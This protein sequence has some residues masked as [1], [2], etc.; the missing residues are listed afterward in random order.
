MRKDQR[1]TDTPCRQDQAGALH[2]RGADQSTSEGLKFQSPQHK[3]HPGRIEES[4]LTQGVLRLAIPAVLEQ[5]LVMIV[6]VISTM[7]VGKLGKEALSA[8]GIVNQTIAFILVLSVALSTGSTV[9]VA[10]LIGEGNR[11]D[12]RDAMRQTVVLGAIGFTIVALVCHAF[13]S[14][15]LHLFFGSAEPAVLRHAEAYF[16][17]SMTGLP[18]LLVNTI[19]SG[20]MR[21][22]GNMKAPMFIAGMVNVLNLTLGIL[23]IFG[24][25]MPAIGLELP[26]YGV[27][28]A[29]WAVSIARM[30][31]GIVSLLWIRNGEGP[32][33]TPLLK[34]FRLNLPLLVRTGRVGLPAMLEQ[35]VMQGGFLMIQIVLAGQGTTTMAVMQIGNSVNSIAFIPTWGFGLA[36]TTLIG[37]SMGEGRPEFAKK[38]GYEANRLCLYVSLTLSLALF[39]FAPQLTAMYTDDPEVLAV[40]I[41][42]IRIFCCSQP[43]LSVVVVLSGAL[44]GAGD[45]TYVMLT[46][47]VGIW[48]MR[49]L[50][51]IV[52]YRWFSL[53]ALSVWFAYG[54]D[55]LVRAA[56]YRHRF[57]RGKWMSIRI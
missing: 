37:Q 38:A 24:V 1:A 3:P 49:L 15:I 33:R 31:G 46:S 42:A 14:S 54:M 36:A 2:P 55:F 47:F 45:I 11:R 6:G 18:F 57:G 41:K 50:L 52:F 48:G 40:G 23:L 5:V 32:L 28:G 53:G 34:G 12:A 39:V 4:R 8:V 17:I 13:S 16:R 35:I 26:A 51:T 27:V 21:G 7:L 30:F 10:R 22:A 20:N 9:L 56:M 25:S 43:F 19:I 44:R 29:A